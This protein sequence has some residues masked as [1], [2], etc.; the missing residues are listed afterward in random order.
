M[1]RTP[2]SRRDFVGTSAAAAGAFTIVPRHVLGGPGFIAPS[3][4]LN[5]ACIGVGGMGRNDV[6]GMSG[7]NIYALCDVDWK[8]A[9]DAFRTFPKA[10]RFKDYREL[11][12]KEAANIDLVTVSTPDHSHAPAAMLSLQ[13]GKPTYTQKPLAR[14]LYE[15]RTL[16]EEA[17][18][19]KLPT[20]MGN[21]GHAGDG[22][23]VLREMVEADLIG[24]V[25][26]VHY[27]TNRPIWPQGM[28]RPSEL[29]APPSTLDWNLWLGP[30]P[31]RPYNPAYMPFKWRGWWDF[32]TGALGDMACH[33]MDA[34]FWILDLGFPDRI[35]PES[36]TLYSETA[37]KS[38]R[39]EY[40]FGAKGK[41]GP[42][43]VVW[44]DGDL[45]PPRPAGYPDDADWPFADIGGQLWLGDKGGILAGIYAENP[46]L[47]DEKQQKDLDANPLPQKYPRSKGVYAEIIDAAKG[48]PPALSSFDGHAG[49]L[50]QMVLLGCLAVRAG[51][52]LELDSKTGMI[53]NV[54]LPEEW[55]KPGFRDGWKV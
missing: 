36:T 8:A 1:P 19:R 4:K 45:R 53:T 21:Q 2:V 40:Q 37:P 5:V 22:M 23:R 7:E 42:I 25:R 27:W 38:E 39:I 49:A 12:D 46:R 50:T 17:R 55:V 48:G 11:F 16:G 44:R 51:K 30:R 43:K 13:A 26:E 18:K 52:T 29:H 54:Q 33:G 41:R 24:T 28:D 15:V 3:D 20:Q 34:A 32:G 6:D 10:R 14:T 47:L 31:D 9:E 35:I